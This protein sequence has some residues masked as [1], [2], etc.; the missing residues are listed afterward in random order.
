[1]EVEDY[2][3][4]EDFEDEVARALIACFETKIIRSKAC[5]KWDNLNPKYLNMVRSTG[6]YIPSNSRLI[7]D[8]P[9]FCWDFIAD[10]VPQRGCMAFKPCTEA[11]SPELKD[12]YF[13]INHIRKVT[14]FS[15]KSWFK[16]SPGQLYEY[17]AVFAKE[18]GIIGERRY[19]TITKN[20]EIISC[21][22]SVL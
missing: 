16:E 2:W 5:A 4:G 15:S 3:A 9:K 14:K 22:E 10:P 20:G 11:Y 19:F 6:L 17:F 21:L 18:K 7:I 13:M 12:S 8:E 1:M